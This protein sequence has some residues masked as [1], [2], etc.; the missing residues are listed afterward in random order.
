M[1]TIDN[2][3]CDLVVDGAVPCY[4]D[5]AEVHAWVHGVVAVPLE[6]GAVRGG[7]GALDPPGALQQPRTGD[8]WRWYSHAQQSDTRLLD[9]LTFGPLLYPHRA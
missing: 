4:P 7:G 3:R 8:R 2:E 9:C 1:N 5:G 6:H